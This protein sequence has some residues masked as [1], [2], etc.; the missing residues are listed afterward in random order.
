M[1]KIFLIIVST[2]STVSF[3]LSAVTFV[4]FDRAGVGVNVNSRAADNS[5]NFGATW[6]FSDTVPLVSDSA[7]TNN[8][9]YGG[10]ASSWVASAAHSPNLRFQTGN[11]LQI[12]V[13][14]LGAD[15]R[16][17]TGMWVWIKEDFQNGLDSSNVFLGAGSLLSADL[18]NVGFLNAVFKMA[19]NQGGSWYVSEQSKTTVDVEVF[20]LDPSATNWAEIDTNTYAI[21]SFAELVLDDV[22][23]V[24]LYFTG[25]RAGTTQLNLQL[26]GYEAVAI[27]EPTT[28]VLLMGVI[29]LLFISIRR[30][31]ILG[32]K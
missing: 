1:K 14:D 20:N 4:N 23:G 28:T 9:V 17:A 22:Q 18:A 5:T 29:G 12:Q 13:N 15:G 26:R 30:K 32:Q 7:G 8:V 24:G 21:G 27:P 16:S 6:A 3:T 11:N 2:L 19:V 10:L 31:I 25:D